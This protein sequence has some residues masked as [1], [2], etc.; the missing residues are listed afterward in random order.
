MKPTKDRLFGPLQPHGRVPVLILSLALGLSGC[1]TLPVGGPSPAPHHS[2]ASFDASALRPGMP[3]AEVRRLEGRPH[4]TY[5]MTGRSM[6]ITEWV[7]EYS[8]RR[9]TLYFTNGFLESWSPER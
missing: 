7:Y 9:T 2:S 3:M 6:S 4:R 5:A 1:A 8:G